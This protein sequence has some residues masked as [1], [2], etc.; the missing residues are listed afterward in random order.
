[1]AA[2]DE[3]GKPRRARRRFLG[4]VVLGADSMTRYTIAG[5]WK[6]EPDAGGEWVLWRDV[7]SLVEAA[8]DVAAR[9]DEAMKALRDVAALPPALPASAAAQRARGVLDEA[10]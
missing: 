10:A 3:R 6:A 5:P 7:R 8:G 1:V 9:H 2:A 4:V